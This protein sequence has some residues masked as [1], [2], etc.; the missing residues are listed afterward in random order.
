MVGARDT[1]GGC[2]SCVLGGCDR[3]DGARGR[4]GR[5]VATFT[6]V[7]A[8]LV[9]ACFAVPAPAVAADAAPELNASSAVVLER[10]TGVTLYEKDADAQHAP[11]QLARVMTALLALEQGDLDQTVTI[12]QADLDA[13]GS[14]AAADLAAG[15]TVT[16]RTLLTCLLVPN[17]DASAYALARQVSGSTDAFVKAMNKRAKKLG[18]S[19]TVFA[20]PTGADADAAHT[21][22][23]DAAKIFAQAM[24]HDEFSQVAGTAQAQVADAENNGARTVSSGDPLITEGSS[25][26]MNGE[27]K[28]AVTGATAASGRVLGA[29]AERDGL[30]VVTVMLD[31]PDIQDASAVK[32]VYIDAKQLLDWALASWQNVSV[33][34]KGEQLTTAPV[35]LSADGDQVPLI[36]ASDITTTVP[37]GS[38]LGKLG[39]KL[40]WKDALEAPVKKGAKL[41]KV[42]VSLDGEKLGS[43]EVTAG[44]GFERSG[45]LVALDFVLNPLNDI[46]VILVITLVV[47]VVGGL[48]KNGAPA[49]SRRG[50]TG[51]GSRRTWFG[52]GRGHRNTFGRGKY[53]KRGFRFGA[54]PGLG[55]PGR[56]APKKRGR[57]GYNNA[58]RGGFVSSYG[59]PAS[60]VSTNAQRKRRG[61]PGT[62]MGRPRPRR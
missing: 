33:A 38:D 16:V 44:A 45:A 42:T 47:V 2:N 59:R 53:N 30:N 18:C 8:L 51:V 43:V 24:T 41:G 61:G 57:A 29:A 19:D 62:S 22:A 31:C 50:Y 54:A 28:A 15:E 46:I 21:T 25:T 1:L 58:R 35:R 55:G 20:N 48:F 36:A 26:Y 4:I 9:A 60:P 6:A 52:L 17:D 14:G 10:T 12:E 37:T 39:Y 11:G 7:A 40:S 23:A 49:R 3:S 27:V 56:Y 34:T 32:V 13:A 5:A